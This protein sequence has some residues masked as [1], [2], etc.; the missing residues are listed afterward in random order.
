[1]HPNYMKKLY[2][3]ISKEPSGFPLKHLCSLNVFLKH[4][5]FPKIVI[6][7]SAWNVEKCFINI[8]NVKENFLHFLHDLLVGVSKVF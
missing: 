4:N 5:K 1:M 2:E 7:F 6:T 3:E 8:M